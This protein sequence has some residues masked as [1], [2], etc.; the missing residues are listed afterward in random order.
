VDD[1]MIIFSLMC[2][3]LAVP[4]VVARMRRRVSLPVYFISISVA[5]ALNVTLFRSL[6]LSFDDLI[7]FGSLAF[8]STGFYFFISSR[9]NRRQ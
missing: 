2:L 9:V 3:G 8:I 5:I 6:T 1:L 4:T 7:P